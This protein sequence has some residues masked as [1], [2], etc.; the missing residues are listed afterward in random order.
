MFLI[1]KHIQSPRNPMDLSEGYKTDEIFAV[2]KNVKSREFS[3]ASIII[4]VAQQK[5]V[6]NRFTERTFDELFAYFMTHYKDQINKW[7]NA[8]IE[9]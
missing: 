7:L 1:A 2:A 3:E 8:Q 6:K 9:K 5:I 4:D